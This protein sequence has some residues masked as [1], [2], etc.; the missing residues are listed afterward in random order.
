[1]N[2]ISAG[3]KYFEGN[4]TGWCDG[5]PGPS[6]SHSPLMRSEIYHCITYLTVLSI[7]KALYSNNPIPCSEPFTGSPLSTLYNGS[8][9]WS[10]SCII[11]L[12]LSPKRHLS[13]STWPLK[14]LCDPWPLHALWASLHALTSSLKALIQPEATCSYLD[15]SLIWDLSC[16]I[17]WFP[18]LRIEWKSSYWIPPRCC[19]HCSGHCEYSREE[20][21][22]ELPALIELLFWLGARDRDRQFISCLELSSSLS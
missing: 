9:R 22:T 19:E 1:M 21:T 16:S 4:K 10:W 8:Q 2:R 6:L 14:P 13:F 5:W 15:P 3:G 7:D 18:I 11:F 12:S 17:L 20:N